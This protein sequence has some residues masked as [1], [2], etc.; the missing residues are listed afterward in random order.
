MNWKKLAIT[1]YFKLYGQRC[2]LCSNLVEY[3]DVHIEISD[4]E[5]YLMHMKCKV[6]EDSE[7]KKHS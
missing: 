3:K 2:V 7:C 1:L 6:K 4:K 5:H